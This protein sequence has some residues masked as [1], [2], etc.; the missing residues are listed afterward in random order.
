MFIGNL[1]YSPFWN[2]MVWEM[3]G[4][5]IMC[6]I[7]VTLYIPSNENGVRL[8]TM[9]IFYFSYYEQ[10]DWLKKNQNW[11]YHIIKHMHMHIYDFKTTYM[12]PFIVFTDLPYCYTSVLIKGEQT[13]YLILIL[14]KKYCHITGTLSR[15]ISITL[16]YFM[17]VILCHA[18]IMLHRSEIIHF[19][20]LKSILSNWLVTSLT[21]LI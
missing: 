19:H 2:V 11:I 4:N 9:L 8:W 12:W 15:F 18:G 20:N 10:S 6:H 3:W 16:Q 21:L 17:I 13:R 1:F 7:Q 14:M 5:P